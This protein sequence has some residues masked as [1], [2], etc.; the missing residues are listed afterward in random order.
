MIDVS[1]MFEECRR[2]I[3]LNLADAA[4]IRDGM[5]PWLD[6]CQQEAPEFAELWKRLRGLDF[7]ADFLRLT[8]WLNEVLATQPPDEE[9]NG[10]WFGLF[11]PCDDQG[12][13]TSQ[14]YLGGSNGFDPESES[15]EWV[16]DL[17]W[18]PNGGVANSQI[19]PKIY[20]LVDSIEEDNVSY[21]GEAFLGHGYLSLFVS[22]WCHGEMKDKMSRQS[23][24]RGIVFGHDSGD[25][26]RAA[27]LP[28]K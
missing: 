26:Y 17:A 15:D 8:D 19:L 6:Y 13:P 24:P 21:L 18:S 25:F 3:D 11:N 27:V 2:L 12:T 14:M 10:F 7:R 20:S 23:G 5:Q 28:T 9:I 1:A 4:C 16:C 22:N